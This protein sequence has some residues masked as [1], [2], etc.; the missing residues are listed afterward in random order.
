MGG[1]MLAFYF[2][3]LFLFLHEIVPNTKYACFNDY[4]SE[5]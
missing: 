5:L 1:E 3:F 2:A 4:A